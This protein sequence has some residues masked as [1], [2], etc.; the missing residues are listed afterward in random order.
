MATVDPR[1]SMP[2]DPNAPL[3]TILREATNDLDRN[4]FLN[5]LITQLRHQ[6]P[7]NPMDDR[8]FIAQMAQFSSL[9][10][11]QNLN[12]TFNRTHAFGMMGQHVMAISRNPITG[13]LTEVAGRVDSVEI[14]AGEPWLVIH[15]EGQEEPDRVRLTDVRMA[16]DDSLALTLTLLSN[17]NNN[18]NS[19]G[20]ISQSL[21][22]VGRYVQ[23]VSGEPPQ[24]IEGRV[25]FID[26]TGPFPMLAIGNERVPVGEVVNIA[27]RSL[28]LG[29]Y[30]GLFASGDI[31]AGGTIQ[32]LSIR[33]GNVY[34]TVG[35]NDH[36]IDQINFLTEAINL[37][38]M[39]AGTPP[40][41]VQY[42]DRDAIVTDAFIRNGQVW[43]GL[44]MQDDDSAEIMPYREFMGFGTAD[45]DE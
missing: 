7:L 41:I 29:Q 18:L 37:R 13:S 38:R 4:A 9:E 3:P 36:R 43:V 20:I 6:D 21:A 25:E 26:F 30:I 2:F 24:F 40:Y 22:L 17:I 44:K 19:S 28:I 33:D 42:D 12:A 10:Q 23:A 1:Y 8:D 31:A 34:A 35:G 27:D 11:M 39:G 45:D 14:R 5:L 32:G 15:R 16:A